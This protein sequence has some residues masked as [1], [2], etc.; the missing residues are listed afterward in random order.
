MM[1]ADLHM[2][3]TTSDGSDTAAQLVQ[4]AIR[5]GVGAIA[6]TDHDTLAHLGRLPSDG[7][8]LVLGGVEISAIDPETGIKAHVLGYDIQDVAPVEQ[9]VAPTRERRHQ[10]S[11]RQIALLKDHGYY[12]D[13]DRICKAD[14]QY[15]YKQHIME[16]L[17]ISGQ[18]P[19]LF[20][21]FYHRVFKHGGFCD[22]DIEYV[23]VRD[24]VA[25]VHRAGG[26]AVLAHP[27]Q[28]QN[29]NLIGALPFDGVELNHP[30]NKPEDRETI[31]ECVNDNST[32][33]FL[34]GGS[35]YHG[36]YNDLPV[37]IGMYTACESGV[38]TLC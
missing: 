37:E 21:Q 4:M 2:H 23:D 16:Y 5:R 13:L 15:I 3:S 18:S 25:A 22:F 1:R 31:M 20:G 6:I 27:G 30:E 24:A 12:I 35:D 34:T 28:Q 38:A 8:V 9:L 7:R 17:V 10:N 19:D 14:G 26:K 36:R 11:L 32:P 33:L 29:F